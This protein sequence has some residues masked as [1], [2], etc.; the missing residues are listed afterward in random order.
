MFSYVVQSIDSDN[1]LTGLRPPIIAPL[2]TAIEFIDCCQAG[3][4][5]W[6]ASL[7]ETTSYLETSLCPCLETPL[8]LLQAQACMIVVNND[9]GGTVECDSN[10]IANACWQ[11]CFMQTN[12]Q[13]KQDDE[14]STAFCNIPAAFGVRPMLPVSYAPAT[15]MRRLNFSRLCGVHRHTQSGHTM[16]WV[17]TRGILRRTDH[18]PVKPSS[19][20]ALYQLYTPPS[21]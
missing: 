5:T 11:I 1:S 6:A 8:G 15:Y 12:L 17:Y 13:H 9:T 20:N 16:M 4:N 19:P 2:F 3:Y 14:L 21:R 10:D 7:F 18:S